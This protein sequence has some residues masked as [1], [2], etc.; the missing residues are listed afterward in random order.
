MNAKTHTRGKRLYLLKLQQWKYLPVEE[1]LVT[2]VIDS[3]T[4]NRSAVGVH[5][6]ASNM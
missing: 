5:V 4:K 1:G 3:I 2:V 6:R